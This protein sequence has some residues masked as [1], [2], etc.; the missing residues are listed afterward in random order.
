QQAMAASAPLRRCTPRTLLQ[1]R[2]SRSRNACRYAQC[3]PVEAWKRTCVGNPCDRNLPTTTAIA[4]R[5][6]HTGND[7]EQAHAA[8]G[9][10]AIR[11]GC[12]G[13]AFGERVLALERWRRRHQ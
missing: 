9:R 3:D 2:R 11:L 13:D 8:V 10:A 7:R 12:L 6:R 5:A 4:D 1:W